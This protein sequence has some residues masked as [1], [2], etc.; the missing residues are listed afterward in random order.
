M[1][2]GKIKVYDGWTYYC[3]FN[4]FFLWTLSWN[5]LGGIFCLK[6]AMWDPK[7]D[8]QHQRTSKRSAVL[9]S[10]KERNKLGLSCAKLRSVNLEQVLFCYFC[11]NK[12]WLA[13]V[14]FVGWM[15]GGGDLKKKYTQFRANSGYL[16]Q[17]YF[18]PKKLAIPLYFHAGRIWGG[19]TVC[20]HVVV[21]PKKQTCFIG[22]QFCQPI[23]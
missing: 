8:N 10:S 15:E 21:F 6:P 3:T 1:T 12:F 18:F 16:E 17:I 4:G 23:A 11:T 13:L 22:H 20:Q 19:G 2:K 14:V 9:N 5:I 7:A